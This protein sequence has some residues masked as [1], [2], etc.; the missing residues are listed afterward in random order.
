MTPWALFVVGTGGLARE[1]ALLVHQT[2][3]GDTHHKQLLQ[4][5]PEL[6]LLRDITLLFK[7]V[8]ADTEHHRA[9]KLGRYSAVDAKMAWRRRR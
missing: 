4:A 2:G 3:A 1:M 9:V 5:A 6:G 7:I 8:L